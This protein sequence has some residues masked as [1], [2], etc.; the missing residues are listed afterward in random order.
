MPQLC[1]SFMMRFKPGNDTGDIV[2]STCKIDVQ[3][4][5]AARADVWLLS[6]VLRDR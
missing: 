4:Q 6:L 3:G 2:L 5:T 1:N